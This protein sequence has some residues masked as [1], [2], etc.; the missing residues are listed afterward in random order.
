MKYIS[1]RLGRF[2][3]FAQRERGFAYLKVTR[4]LGEISFALPFCS[5]AFINHRMFA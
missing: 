3:V 2:E 4:E 1:L 5:I